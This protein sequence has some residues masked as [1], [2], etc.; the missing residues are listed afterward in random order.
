MTTSATATAATTAFHPSA[1]AAND[2]D[3]HHQDIN[4]NR[5]NNSDIDDDT[6]FVPKLYLLM[7]NKSKSNNLGPI[8]RCATAFGIETMI[9]VGYSK[10]STEGE[11][12]QLRRDVHALVLY[13]WIDF[14]RIRTHFRIYSSFPPSFLPIP[15]LG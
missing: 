5:S 15:F 9:V 8:L 2:I 12:F 11:S 7:E 14:G 6:H 1:T 4:D 13:I 3:D 10:C